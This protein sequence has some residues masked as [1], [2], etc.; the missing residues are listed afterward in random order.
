[1]KHTTTNGGVGSGDGRDESDLR[2]RRSVLKILGV[3]D[4]V[5]F[6]PRFS[7]HRACGAASWG[8]VRRGGWPASN[9]WGGAPRA[10]AS[11]G[12]APPTPRAVWSLER[13]NRWRSSVG[14][15]PEA[16]WTVGGPAKV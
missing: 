8:F 15:G 3:K 5:T 7:V 14:A 2:D 10:R 16:H 4:S 11:D 12:A 9:Q 1:M 6:V 13:R